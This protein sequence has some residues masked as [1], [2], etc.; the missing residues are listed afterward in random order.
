MK[1]DK[2]VITHLNKLLGNELVAINQYFLHARMFRNWGLSR[3]NDIEY[4]ESIDEMK[5]ADKYI[6]RILFLEGI[7]NLQDLGKLRIGE[8]VEEML[9][10]DL[11]LELEGATD[12]RE[13]IAHADKVHDYVTRDLLI[14]ILADEEHHIDWLET[15]LELITRVGIQNYIQTQIKEQAAG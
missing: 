14:E 6:E 5:H 15:E 8:D 7:P 12:L 2:K 1:G 9:R 11:S 10:S 3:L 4:H 13:A